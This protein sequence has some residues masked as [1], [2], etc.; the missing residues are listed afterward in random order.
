ME[1]SS[2]KKSCMP[3]PAPSRGDV[4]VNKELKKRVFFNQK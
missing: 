2:T 1:T 4:H 3:H